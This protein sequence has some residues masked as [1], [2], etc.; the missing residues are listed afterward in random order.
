MDLHIC[1]LSILRAVFIL[2]EHAG[3]QE[4]SASWCYKVLLEKRLYVF[5]QFLGT[6]I[7]WDSSLNSA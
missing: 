2:G 4:N 5:W 1:A 6:G 7:Q 3:N